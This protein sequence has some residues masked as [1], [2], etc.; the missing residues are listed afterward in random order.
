MLQILLRTLLIYIL[1]L[2]TVRLMGKRQL[3]ELEV[4]E[5]VTTILISEIAALPLADTNFPI[6]YS[7]ISL[8]TI[9]TLEVS[10]SVILLKCPRLKNIASSR[11]NILI[12][13]GVLNQKEMLRIRISIDELISQVRQAGLGNIADVD[14]AILEQNG[15]ISIIPRKSTQPPSAED[16]HFPVAETGISHIIV[17]DGRLNAHNMRMMKLKPEKLKA[18]LRKEKLKLA[19]LFLL[20]MNDGGEF[21]YI[22]KDGK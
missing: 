14:Y 6:T 8:V 19:D 2:A 22:K 20:G 12:R 7:V 21:Y 4:S 3:G 11:P 18:Y 17:E 9:I 10:L 15:R 1:L 16:L 5:L 13:H